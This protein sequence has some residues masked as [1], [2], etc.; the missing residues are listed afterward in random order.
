MNL[1]QAILHLHPDAD[2]LR[3][4]T[5]QDDGKGP[6]IAAWNLPAEKP[7]KEELATAWA[8][9]QEQEAGTEYR[10]LREAEYPP[11][12]DQLD[13]IWE[14]EAAT[15]AMRAKIKAVKDKYPKPR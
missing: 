15:D 11:I 13:A 5:V 1:S 12:T 3:D 2:P 10:R 7:T 4:F 8:A 14:G 6:F 9:R